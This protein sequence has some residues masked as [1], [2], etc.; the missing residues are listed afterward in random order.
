MIGGESF[1][2]EANLEL[3]RLLAKLLGV[4]RAQVA[5][6]SGQTSKNKVVRVDGLSA[7]EAGKILDSLLGG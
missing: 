1:E 2:G 7:V 6:I 5:I 3:I 4:Q